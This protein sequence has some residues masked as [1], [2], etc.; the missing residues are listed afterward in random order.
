MIRLLFMHRSI[1]TLMY[2]FSRL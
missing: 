2:P 1:H